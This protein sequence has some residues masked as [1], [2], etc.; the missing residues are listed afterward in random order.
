MVSSVL[1]ST[2]SSGL[3]Y[4]LPH[5]IT[6]RE[7]CFFVLAQV[8]LSSAAGG[9][10]QQW[11]PQDI[12]RKFAMQMFKIEGGLREGKP[13]LWADLGQEEIALWDGGS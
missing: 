10:P 12:M 7:L 2:T 4:A 8:I 13:I 3:D 5:T 6:L 11:T 1:A 9:W